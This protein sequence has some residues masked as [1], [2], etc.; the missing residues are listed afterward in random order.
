MRGRP[1][2][3]KTILTTW[4]ISYGAVMQKNED[5]AKLLQLWGYLDSQDLW[6]E[7]LKWQHYKNSAPE[8]LRRITTTE[9]AFLDTIQALVE[10]SLIEEKEGSTCYSMHSVVHDWIKGHINQGKVNGMLRTSICC[11]GFTIPSLFTEGV[12]R[13]IR[14][15]QPHAILLSRSYITEGHFLGG[16]DEDEAYYYALWFIALILSQGSK[17]GEAL[18]FNSFLLL[19][20]Q[21]FLGN[22][23]ELV[24][25]IMFIVGDIHDYQNNLADAEA[26]YKKALDRCKYAS[27]PDNLLKLEITVKL[28]GLYFQQNRLAEA[29]LLY[30]QALEGGTK[31]PRSEFMGVIIG[32][33]ELSS[34]QGKLVEAEDL[35]KQCLSGIDGGQGIDQ[36]STLAAVKGLA[37]LYMRIGNLPLAEEFHKRAL[38]TREEI[39]GVEDLANWPTAYKLGVIYYRQGKL[40]DAQA[41]LKRVSAEYKNIYGVSHM[42]TVAAME[43]LELVE[44]ELREQEESE[45]LQKETPSYNIP[46]E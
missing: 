25:C 11:V 3:S 33:A 26:I 23:H 20:A 9:L 28:S 16:R 21:R 5:A 6:Y 35:Y 27:N 4:S 7:L 29:E 15:L 8:W 17:L 19:R 31:I 18:E 42:V 1:D 30:E 32:L 45:R 38:K 40:P 41:L 39:F 34:M 14:R 46:Q 13:T 22:N 10:F 12:W 44:K 37:E 2:Y 24:L 43:I 36:V